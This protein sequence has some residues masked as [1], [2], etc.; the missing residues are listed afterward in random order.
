[1][2]ICSSFSIATTANGPSCSC[3]PLPEKIPLRLRADGLYTIERVPV[4]LRDQH[5][6]TARRYGVPAQEYRKLTFDKTLQQRDEH[7]DAILLSPGHPLFAAMGEV[8]LDDLEGVQGHTAIFV[9]PRVTE[10]YQAHFFEVQIVSEEPLTETKHSSIGEAR[11]QVLYATLAAVIDGPHSERS[12]AV[13]G[14]EKRPPHPCGVRSVTSRRTRSS[15]CWRDLGASTFALAA[16][17]AVNR[18]CKKN[19]RSGQFPLAE[20]RCLIVFPL[21]HSQAESR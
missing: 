12:R 2:R 9:D 11:T 14:T 1:M 3:D 5:L 20:K 7:L 18:S 13:C 16:W 6:S 8:L 15:N 17:I 10:S 21:P 19:E 4:R